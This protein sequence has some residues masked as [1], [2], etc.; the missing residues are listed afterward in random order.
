MSDDGM[1]WL[2]EALRVVREVRDWTSARTRRTPSADAAHRAVARAARVTEEAVEAAE[3]GEP[4]TSIPIEPIGPVPEPKPRPPQKNRHPERGERLAEDQEIPLDL[5]DAQALSVVRRL[6]RFGHKAYLVG[7]CVRDLL[8]GLT[9]KDFDIATDAKPEEVKSI[10]RNSRIIGRRFRLVHLY[11]RG[12]KI[13]EVSTFRAMIEADDDGDDLLIRRDNVFGTE[14]EDA[15]RRDFTIN[16]LFYDIISGRIIDHVGGMPDIRSRYLRMIGDP[17]IRLREDPVRI[18]RAIRFLAKVDLNMDPELERAIRET[19]DDIRLCAPA[20]ILEETLRLLR[21]GHSERT[22]ELMDRTGV[23]AVLLPEIEDYLREEEPEED[24]PGHRDLLFVHLKA[25]DEL[26]ARGPVSDS[27]VLGALLYAP[28]THALE[29]ADHQGLDRNRELVKF[30]G[31]VGNRISLTRRLSE[32]LRQL[33]M[34]QRHLGKSAPAGGR[35][36][37][38]VAPNVLVK[39]A[40]FPDA[41]NLYEIHARAMKLPLDDVR[42]W[43]VRA[44]SSGVDVDPPF[45]ING[46]GGAPTEPK[47]SNPPKRRRRRRRRKKSS[48]A[49]QQ[50]QTN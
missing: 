7:G 47:A 42:E 35:K 6:H 1:E 10:F 5:I 3:R 12:G 18:L 9:P 2:I 45:P 50:R 11:F 20:R 30:L 44:R 13:I 22:V 39:R 21:I 29:H 37:R 4:V 31:T 41:L 28:L 48:G 40:F 23:L 33:F 43:H 16:G 24:A 8:L 19:K 26:V 38:R 27:V 32:H 36:R 17:D 34:A 14:E 46:A 15:R 25:L 49:D